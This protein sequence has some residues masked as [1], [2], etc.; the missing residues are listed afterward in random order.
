MFL[1]MMQLLYVWSID[2]TCIVAEQPD[3]CVVDFSYSPHLVT[4]LMEWRFE[5]RKKTLLF[6]RGT[7]P[8]RPR[9]E[10]SEGMLAVA[11]VSEC[12]AARPIRHTSVTR[13]RTAWRYWRADFTVLASDHG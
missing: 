8:L 9:E 5:W 4:D 12:R 13:R 10:R 3:V 6:N 2:T 7:T 1:G 11:S